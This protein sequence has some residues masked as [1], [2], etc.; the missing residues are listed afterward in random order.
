MAKLL[1]IATISSPVGA[2][3]YTEE[4]L[5][6]ALEKRAE[7]LDLI[8]GKL[9]INANQVSVGFELNGDNADLRDWI[10]FADAELAALDIEINPVML[11]SVVNSNPMTPIDTRV[12]DPVNFEIAA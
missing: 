6:Q 3:L 5:V 2:K 12:V 7:E 11:C 10:D 1:F 8:P 9:E 4:G